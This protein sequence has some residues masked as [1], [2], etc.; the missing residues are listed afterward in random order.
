M[1]DTLYLIDAMGFAFRSYFAIR[2]ALTDSKGRPTNA[3]Y[4]FARV[5]LKTLRE[6][7][8]K[9]I[10][11]VFDAPGKTFRDEM[12]PAY[13]ATR[14][15]TPQDLKDQF[16]M[17]H[18]LVEA[19]NLP[20][21]VTPG[22]EADD[23]MGTLARLAE[24]QGMEAVLVT[25]D[26]DMQQ[27][28]TEKVKVFDPG[29]GDE[30]V[31]IGIPEVRERFGSDPKH[32]VDAL[33]LIGDTADNIPGVRGI[34]DK[35]ARTIIE[36][37]G[38]L[39]NIYAHIDEFKGKQKERLIEDREQAFFSR[40]L[41]TIKIDVPL[42]RGP[43]ECARNE[44]DRDTIIEVFGEFDFHALLE[45][46]IP[47]GGQEEQEELHYHLVLTEAELK[48]AVAEM[49]NAGRCAIDTETTSTDPM[50]ADLVGFSM[51]CQAGTGY[52]V[53][54]GHQPD[55][56]IFQRDPD[57][58]TTFEELKMM[59]RD[60][61]MSLLRD[62]VG[63]AGVAKIGHNIKYDMIVLERAEAPVAG[64]AMDTMVASYLTDPSRMRHN[65]DEVSL[66]YLRRKLI[67]ISD[68]IG[69]GSKAVTFDHVPV[70]RASDYACEDADM[71][72]RLAEVFGPQLRERELEELFKS[73]ELP[74]ISVLARMEQAGI[75]ID[76]A[77]FEALRIEIEGRLAELERAI[78]ELA[79]EPFNINSP[80]QLQE[81]LFTKL[82]LKPLRKTKTGN[83]TDVDVLEQLS[84]QHEL[85]KHLL[86][87]RTLEKLRGTYVDA[88]PKMVHP[89][90][91]RIHTSF[92]QAVAATGRLS[93]SDPNLQN[94]PVRT[95]YGK[96]IREGF[97]AAP[98][99]MLI[100]ADYSQIELRILAHLSQ[101]AAL[102]EAFAR[103]EDIHRDTASRV[104]GVAAE[105]VDSEM[106]RRAKAVNFGVVYGISAFGLARNLG[107]SNGEA[108]QFI[109]A[110]FAQYPGV[111]A[112]L[113]STIETA[114]ERGYVTTLLNR[115]R[116]VPELRSSDV[117][118]RRAA[119]RATINTPVQGSAADIIKLA[120]VR[121]DTA[122]A[123]KTAR[124]LLQ[125]HDELVVEV[126][127]RAAAEVAALMKEVM[128][129]A[130][131]LDVHLR[132]DVGIGR[133]WAEIH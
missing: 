8:P 9:Y 48:A 30:G 52:Y 68:L 12:Y 116:Y 70:H 23:V 24:A 2:A 51:S 129:Q 104:F 130:L 122:L 25:A 43:R 27:L 60:A 38:S 61:A 19:L 71:T 98:G 96:R 111:K 100:S 124:M 126:E 97:V 120:M 66:H 91:G 87:F 93:S 26:K 102:K 20:L 50:R 125:V 88:L 73:V 37:Y 21:F 15:E 101:D 62:F 54:V 75:A 40:E 103:D 92:N 89:E 32:V 1:A 17:M 56:F 33:A 109:D 3:L 112:W 65:L 7:D 39:E 44:F 22:V 84:E 42:D 29:K 59:P 79:G 117:N 36:K 58:L 11:V 41:A 94:I 76:P 6:R 133:N 99:H 127:E 128:E 123:G 131:P 110:Y 77:V 35:T 82:G 47:K 57:D 67:P 46:L 107:I 108:Q 132:V 28:V 69:R 72:W 95:G 18:R 4:G 49:R 115:R 119:E 121:L 10:A 90:T 78:F 113:D 74:L 55:A 81:I 80:K 114:R 53:P 86:E 118:T 106:R 45:E 5:L 34:G 16:P 64:I 85:P 105:Q 83:S 13:K 14:Q 31:W 63:D